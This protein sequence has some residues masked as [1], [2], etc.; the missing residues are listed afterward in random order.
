M[1]PAPGRRRTYAQRLNCGYGGVSLVTCKGRRT[2]NVWW[3]GE[4]YRC[5]GGASC[6]TFPRRL[7]NTKVWG[8]SPNLEFMLCPVPAPRLASPPWSAALAAPIRNVIANDVVAS[9]MFKERSSGA[10]ELPKCIVEA[11]SRPISCLRGKTAL[12]ARSPLWRSA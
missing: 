9:R 11:G 5:L 2:R 4:P 10:Y 1:Q 3:P 7:P 6:D 12:P 8:S